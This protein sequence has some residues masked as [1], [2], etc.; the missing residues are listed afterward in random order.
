MPSAGLY[1]PGLA[2][3][4]Q[5]LLVLLPDYLLLARQVYAEP[6]RLLLYLLM[7]SVDLQLVEFELLVVVS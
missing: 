1:W 7:P 2:T 3:L 4:V 5:Q 6:R